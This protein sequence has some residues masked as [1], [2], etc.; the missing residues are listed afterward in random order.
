MI[1]KFT[2]RDM[3]RILEIESNSFPKSAY[4][5]F[6]FFYF[7]R[8]YQFLVY[9]D[10]KIIAYII[11]DERNG[12]IASIA[13]DPLHRRRGIGTR[14]VE[15]VLKT[16]GRAW[17]EVRVSNKTAQAFYEVLG[18]IKIAVIPNYYREEDAHVMARSR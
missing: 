11:F 4:D 14:L 3:R 17:A 16:C 2:H 8:L 12:H 18:F 7:S 15:E 13:V 5:R 10:E 1:R 9:K 6:T